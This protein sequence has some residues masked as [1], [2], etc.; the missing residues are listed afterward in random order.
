MKEDKHM[1]EEFGRLPGY[2]SILLGN[3]AGGFA[4]ATNFAT[5]IYPATMAAGDFNADG[6]LDVATAD[7]ASN[8]LWIM[9]GD[10]AGGVAPPVGFELGGAGTVDTS[11]ITTGDFNGDGKLDLATANGHSVE[12][13]LNGCLAKTAPVAAGD[14]YSTSEDT[15]L[16]ISVPGVLGNDTDSQNSTLTATLVTNPPHGTL[17]FNSNGSFSYTPAANYF[18]PDSFSYKVS[19]GNLESNIA[20]VSITVNS[21]ND[22]PSAVNDSATVA[23]NSGA[24]TI[25]VLSNDTDTE[26]DALTVSSVIQGAHGSVAVTN[27]GSN[28]S[29]TPNAN[30]TGSDSFTYT[31]SDGNGGTSTATVSVSVLAPTAAPA[32]I[33]GRVMTDKG[34]G[35]KGASVTV[36][37]GD[38]SQPRTA[39]TNTF[40]NFSF[41][42]LTAGRVYV[43]TVSSRRYV[44]EV[45]TR[46]VKLMDD[47]SDLNF[48]ASK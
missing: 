32:S 6:K 1:L 34:K 35:I 33:S 26:N 31:I 48:I 30:Y 27:G 29:Y 21:V 37:G 2:V 14:S 12:V 25:N 40:G 20:T 22:A 5:G 15:L 18:G 8:K 41:E 16:S 46:V 43:V 3:G 47:V 24:N 13:V 39:V 28:I 7:L 38:L 11:D 36:A 4:A 10:G 45:P 19:D 44:F 9:F 42:G 17:V 23:K